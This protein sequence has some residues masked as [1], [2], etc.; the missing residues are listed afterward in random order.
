MTSF[1]GAQSRGTF[2]V[3]DDEPD[4]LDAIARLFRKEY[5]VLTAQSVEEALKLIATHNVQV[6]MTDQRMPKM[7]GIEFLAELRQE[8]PEIVRV[9]FTG[10][11]NISDVIDA[12]NEGHVYRYISKPWKPVELRL[13]VAQDRK[14]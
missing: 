5:T 3:V 13:F 8:H 9:L 11:S 1:T 14:S 4:I 12:I 7:S 2:L 10:Y 6:V